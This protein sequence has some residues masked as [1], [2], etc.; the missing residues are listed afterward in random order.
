MN[1]KVQGNVGSVLNGSDPIL[2]AL[3]GKQEPKFD[4]ITGSWNG[5]TA[6]WLSEERNNVTQSRQPA[7]RRIVAGLSQKRMLGVMSEIC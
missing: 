3:G 6:M 4:D 7:A 5:V 1:Q 2:T